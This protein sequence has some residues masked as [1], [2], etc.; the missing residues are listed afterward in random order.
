MNSG[1]ALIQ[2]F[3]GKMR[4]SCLPVLP[5]SAEAQVIWGGSA[6]RLLIAYFISNIS[7]KKNIKMRSRVSVIAN[8]RWDVF[9]RHS[10]VTQHLECQTKIILNLPFA[11][12]FKLSGL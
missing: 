2:H 5:R 8:Q 6:K 11:V 4:F 12:R 7:A 3:S 9:L 10:V 1:N